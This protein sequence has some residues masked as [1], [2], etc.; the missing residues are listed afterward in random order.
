MNKI[1]IV[2][3]LLLLAWSAQG[4]QKNGYENLPP[5]KK[6]GTMVIALSNNPKVM[7]PVLSQDAN[8]AEVE[9]YL[10][11][12]LLMM[13]GDS[14]NYLPYLAEKYEVSKDHKT[15]TF[16]LN[17]KAQWQDGTPV[18]AH[19]VKFTFDKIMDP[20]VD[21]AQTRVYFEGTTLTVLGDHKFQFVVQNPKFSTLM[22]LALFKPIQ[23]KQF[24]NEPNFNLSKNMLKPISN[25]A[26]QL[27]GFSRDQKVEFELNPNWWGFQYRHFKNIMNAQRV[28]LKI[29]TDPSLQYEKFIKGDIDVIDLSSTGIEIYANKVRGVDAARVG[30][31]AT[32]GKSVWANHFDNKGLRPY[33]YLGWNHKNSLFSS[34]EV[35]KALGHLVDYQQI[36]NK[37]YYGYFFQCTSPFGSKSMFSDA[38]LRKP[39]KM[40]SFDRKKGIELLKKEGWADTDGDNVL[41]RVVNGKKVPFRFSLKYNSNN[42]LRAKV[43]QIIR[44]NFK[45]AGIDV[46]I[47]A[48]E[49]NAYI[50]DVS[51]KN[52]EA[53]IL[54]WLP[55]LTMNPKQVWHTDSA[56]DEGS[57]YISYSNPKVDVLIEKVNAEFDLKKRVKIFQELNRLIYSDQPYTFLV[58]PGYVIGGFNSKLK[59]S[60]WVMDYSQGPDTSL[61]SVVE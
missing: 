39:G 15:Y 44:E 25:T 53:F 5:A 56:K 38:D 41:D 17:P 18:T 2:G 24:E 33:M 23:K 51:K 8:S 27:V 43:A 20:K 58:E 4:A 42:P 30:Q 11:A 35:R 32:E 9:G 61:Y 59:S 40:I 3:V 50:E 1:S 7:N 6:G 13:D 29:V 55:S 36:I 26:Y 46:Q 34:V 47:M 31:S 37:V 49:W 10:F 45:A 57:N 19:D 60:R 14:L 16:T 21:A 28:I 54:G 12:S 48:V 22:T 52:F